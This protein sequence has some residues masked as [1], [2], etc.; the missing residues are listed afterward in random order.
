[1]RALHVHG[2]VHTDSRDANVLWD[3]ETER[4]MII[5]FEHAVLMELLLP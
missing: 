1:V 3:L 2:V 4:V 5:D